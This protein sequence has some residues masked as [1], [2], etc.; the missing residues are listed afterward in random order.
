MVVVTESF[1]RAQGL[2]SLVRWNYSFMEGYIYFLP[3]HGE[4]CFKFWPSL[5]GIQLVI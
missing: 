2:S 3:A 5:Q 1:S 4:F